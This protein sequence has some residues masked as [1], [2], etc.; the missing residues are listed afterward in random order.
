LVIDSID[1]K[2]FN[3]IHQAGY[4]EYNIGNIEV[5]P[6]NSFYAQKFLISLDEQQTF[7]SKDNFKDHSIFLKNNSNTQLYQIYQLLKSGKT[8][9]EIQKLYDEEIQIDSQN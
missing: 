3:D 9:D 1:P 8:L 5:K 2:I 6:L 4:H 7:T